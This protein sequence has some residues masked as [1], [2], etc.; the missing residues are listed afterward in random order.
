MILWLDNPAVFPPRKESFSSTSRKEPL[1]PFE[2]KF[3]FCL[4]K[5]VF[6]DILK[7]RFGGV[8]WFVFGFLN[9]SV[10][11]RRFH[12]QERLWLMFALSIMMESL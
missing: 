11:K 2:V 8:I 10:G 1:F 3:F 5:I 9:N 4:F 12:T 6:L 7:V